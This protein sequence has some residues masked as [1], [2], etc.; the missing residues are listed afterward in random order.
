[1]SSDINSLLLYI[2]LRIK[3]LWNYKTITILIIWVKT[4]YKFKYHRILF[5]YCNYFLDLVRNNWAV[6]DTRRM[7]NHLSRT[8][9][10]R[11]SCNLNELKLLSQLVQTSI[12]SDCVKMLCILNK[13]IKIKKNFDVIKLYKFIKFI[14]NETE[15]TF[16]FPWS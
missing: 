2:I 7:T 14:Y 13:H 6:R 16:F 3:D 1:M 11:T 4:R 12:F 5:I 9:S 15:Q 10:H 8:S